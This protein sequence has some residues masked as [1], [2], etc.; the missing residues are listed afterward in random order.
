MSAQKALQNLK[1]DSKILRDSVDAGGSPQDVPV[2][3]I[4]Q[5]NGKGSGLLLQEFRSVYMVFQS[6]NQLLTMSINPNVHL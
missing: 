3:F 5:S 1:R 6:H 4:G 2:S